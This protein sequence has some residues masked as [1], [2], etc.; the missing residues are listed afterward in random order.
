MS[1][2]NDPFAGGLNGPLVGPGSQPKDEDG[3]VLEYMQMPADMMTFA[4]PVL[5][6]P[7]ETDGLSD[8]LSALEAVLSMLRG[9]S[10]AAPAGRVDLAH[11]DEA[12][13]DLVNQVLGEGEVSVIAGTDLQA[14]ESVLAGV[15]RLRSAG[16]AG[17]ADYVE[18]GAFPG[19]VLKGAFKGADAVVKVPETM[20]GEN[21]FNAP[22]LIAEI[23]EHVPKSDV[24][25][26]PHVINL[27]LLPHTEEDLAFLTSCLGRGDVTIL[28]RGYGNCRITSTTTRNTWWVQFY[29]SQ[30]SLILNSIEIV[31]VPEVACA[32]A[33]DIADSANRLDEIL[34]I[35]R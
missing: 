17:P 32:A 24:V 16:A 29:N 22:P 23:N 4:A 25:P 34:E 21:I 19:A 9:Y 14:Q 20:T 33:E 3:G 35:Y 11:L 15:W 12:N 31:K 5:P 7:E 1:T 6:E 18:V 2:M 28:S 26:G 13:L 27:S 10:A 8:G 30:D